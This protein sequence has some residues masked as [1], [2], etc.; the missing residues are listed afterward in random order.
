MSTIFGDVD[1]SPPI[2]ERVRYGGLSL[3]ASIPVILESRLIRRPVSQTS[4]GE[5]DAIYI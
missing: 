2:V 4:L 3:Q 5:G 1:L